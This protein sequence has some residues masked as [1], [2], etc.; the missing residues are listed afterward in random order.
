MATSHRLGTF[1]A[2]ALILGVVL[3]SG[4]YVRD[5]FRTH[6]R[7]LESLAVVAAIAGSRA[8]L[9]AQG[10]R[11]APAPAQVSGSGRLLFVGHIYS[12]SGSDVANTPRLT[13]DPL[14]VLRS[15][16][17]THT[18]KR[19][20][21]GG[22]NLRVPTAEALDHLD[23]S[24]ARLP[25]RFV[26]GNHDAYWRVDSVLAATYPWLYHARHAAEDIDGVRLV[27][28]HSVARDGSYGLD[29]DAL[30]FLEGQL[31]GVDY[32]Y[33]LVFLHHALWAGNTIYANT[34]YRKADSLAQ[35]WASHIAPRLAAGRV[36][37]VFAG[38]GGVRAPGRRLDVAG[39][40]HYV[41]GWP[42]E[43]LDIL[44]E[45][46]EI[47]LGA[48]GVRVTWYAVLA[49]EVYSRQEGAPAH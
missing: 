11:R 41:T 13:H 36:V 39:I 28:L 43:R 24:T 16:A 7:R 20:I 1:W 38:D 37:A 29:S 2:L 12:R 8:T 26:L 33:A 10:Y 45:W 32:R 5:L 22:D 18:V 4:L 6:W 34:L 19:V 40:P 17:R 35:H 25:R 48:G 27:Y 47:D 30:D 46:L 44:P 23:L 3:V 21:F 42:M 15:A 49:G 14:E 9:L 31:S